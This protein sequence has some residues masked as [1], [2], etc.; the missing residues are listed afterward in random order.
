MTFR[1]LTLLT[2]AVVAALTGMNPPAAEAA[3]VS[4]WGTAMQGPYAVGGQSS[5]PPPNSALP[6]GAARDQTLRL[7]VRTTVGGTALR[8][9]L[10][11]ALGTEAVTFGAARVGVRTG[12]AAVV[13]GS[14]RPLTFASSGSVTV[15]AGEQQVSDP[16]TFDV[17]K[18][19]DLA[20]SLHVSGKSGTA[21]YHRRALTTSYLSMP[22]TGDHTGE[23]TTGSF[24]HTTSSWYWLDGVEVLAPDDAGAVVVLGDSITDGSFATLD[25]NDRWTD[26]LARRLAARADSG[27]GVVNAGIGGN[28][29]SPRPCAS[30]GPAALERLERD[31]FSRT[32]TAVIV[33][34]GT[35]DLGWRSPASDVIAALKRVAQ[36]ARARG[37]RS[38]GAT[39][40][41]RGGSSDWTP[42]KESARQEVNAFIRNGGAFDAVVDMDAATRDDEL[43]D[44]LRPAFDSGDHL[45]PN[46]AGFAAMGSAVDLSLLPPSQTS[47]DA[48]VEP[49]PPLPPAPREVAPV[50]TA[51]AYAPSPTPPTSPVV[52]PNRLSV[53]APAR[54]CRG[55]SR[56]GVSRLV[57]RGLSCRAAWPVAR[58]Y[59][60]KPE[61]RVGRYT[62][63]AVRRTAVRRSVTCRRDRVMLRFDHTRHRT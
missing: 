24:T 12:G 42:A 13:K 19:T 3:W 37:L 60:S 1:R 32:A 36:A 35:N 38:I 41:P 52:G 22:G 27:T 49:P 50:A 53:T 30:C 25:R 11:N 57:T 54:R 45:H 63:R 34:E 51:P 56:G 29:L 39:I 17:A 6:G 10:S 2:F 46:P 4:T 59:A 58:R 18:G 8:I 15:A 28:M 7:V 16:V 43:P 40:L 20:V 23:T 44:R 47:G 31:V 55:R 21:T 26:V 33:L 62:C 9:R 48:P 5:S 14:N 61:R